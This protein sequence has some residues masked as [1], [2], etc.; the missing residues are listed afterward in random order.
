M[1]RGRNFTDE[2]ASRY[3]VGDIMHIMW[4]QFSGMIYGVQRLNLGRRM[5]PSAWNRRSGGG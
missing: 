2:M 3:W 5:D 4:Y 1:L